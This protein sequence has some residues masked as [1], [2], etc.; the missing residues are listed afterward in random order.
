MFMDAFQNNLIRFGKQHVKL[1]CEKCKHFSIECVSF[2]GILRY[3]TK[4][5][6][7]LELCAVNVL[8][9]PKSDTPIC[10][11]YKKKQKQ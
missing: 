9:R 1:T 4:F 10:V 7:F 8:P 3:N 2:H 11:Q 5:V 6:T